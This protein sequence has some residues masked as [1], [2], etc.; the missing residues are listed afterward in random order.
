MATHPPLRINDALVIPGHEIEVTFTRSGGPGGQNV[1]KVE[2]CAILR[3][4]IPRSAALTPEQ[5]AQLRSSLG[6]R[7][8]AAGE[9]LVRADRHRE[10]SKNEADGMERLARLLA[11]GLSRPK[12]R[13]RSRPTRALT[14]SASP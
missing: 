5:R 3:F 1:N 11:K 12:P 2:T 7:L 4:S 10:R 9:V 8:T 14:R 13:K 6:P